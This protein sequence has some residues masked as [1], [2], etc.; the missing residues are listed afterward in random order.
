MDQLRLMG[1][2]IL[3]GILKSLDGYSAAESGAIAH[4]RMNFV[5][6]S[7]LRLINWLSIIF[8]K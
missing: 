5:R 4:T 7:P 6:L 2:V 3:T 1:P 8:N